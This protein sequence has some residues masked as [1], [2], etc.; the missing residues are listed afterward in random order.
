MGADAIIDVGA[1]RGELLTALA[2]GEGP[3]RLHG[4]DLVARPSGL[5]DVVGWSAG[6]DALPAGALAGA[7]VIAWEVLDVVP[8]P[9]LEVDPAGELREVRVDPGGRERPAGPPSSAD[10]Q[11]C[12]RWWPPAGPGSR[13]EVGR[14]RDAF[15]GGLVTRARRGAARALLAVDYAHTAADRPPR[16]SLTGFRAG[17]QVPPV[18]DGSC[19]LTAH[20]A[21][22]AVEACG[23][24]A[25]A[26]TLESTD[27]RTALRRLGVSGRASGDATPAATLIR[28]GQEA[29]LLDPG[30]L[31]SFG[32]LLQVLPPGT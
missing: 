9:V 29:E 14:L 4:V 3:P 32:W 1:G 27:Q 2:A 23:I 10:L 6:L 21:L 5:P 18:P 25:G 7:L 13:I 31:G 8:C 26:R 22:D 17:R 12:A 24:E 20:V 28:A 19:D 11:W 16:G 30:G 15:W